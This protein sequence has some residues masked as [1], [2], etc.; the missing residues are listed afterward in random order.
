[1][2]FLDLVSPDFLA[3]YAEAFNIWKPWTRS[4]NWVSLKTLN[5]FVIEI[6]T[7]QWTYSLQ[8]APSSFM[9]IVT[10]AAPRIREAC[11]SGQT[12]AVEFFTVV[13][14]ELFHDEKLQPLYDRLIHIQIQAR[15]F[16]TEFFHG[17]K[18]GPYGAN[19][20]LELLKDIYVT[21]SKLKPHSTTVDAVKKDM[22]IKDIHRLSH[23]LKILICD[24]K[25]RIHPSE[26]VP[27]GFRNLAELLDSDFK[28]I[29]VSFLRI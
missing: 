9:F 10:D 12:D 8:D 1:M 22:V 13:S 15:D 14:S 7:L 17:F 4:A 26:Y 11:H 19:F 18:M 28:D 27:D 25:T 20:L 5:R 2:T 16:D 3:A 6:G 24:F 29:P 21:I 23:C